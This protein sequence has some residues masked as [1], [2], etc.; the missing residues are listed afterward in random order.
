MQWEQSHPPSINSPKKPWLSRG[1]LHIFG[2]IEKG[3]LGGWDCRGN[4]YN[5]ICILDEYKYRYIYIYIYIYIYHSLCL[6]SIQK[7]QQQSPVL[8]WRACFTFHR[9]LRDG[10][11]GLRGSSLGTHGIP[12]TGRQPENGDL[13]LN[14]KIREPMG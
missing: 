1:G 10:L 4:I 5:H 3:R 9:S 7:I 6:L 2:I 14:P 11:L 12:R 8:P 13:S